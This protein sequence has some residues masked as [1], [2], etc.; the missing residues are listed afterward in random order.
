[1][2]INL[3]GMNP[4]RAQDIVDETVI[5]MRTVMRQPG[6]REAIRRKVATLRAEGF[7]DR[8]PAA[9]QERSA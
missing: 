5:F 2:D 3:A 7:F 4:Y 9:V 1:M 8:F 6:M